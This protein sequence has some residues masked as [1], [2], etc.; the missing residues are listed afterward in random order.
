[1]AYCHREL[2]VCAKLWKKLVVLAYHNKDLQVPVYLLMK[3]TS[4]CSL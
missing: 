2:M 4:I 3:A 1:M